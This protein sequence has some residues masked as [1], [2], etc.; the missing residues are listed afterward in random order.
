MTSEKS[1]RVRTLS[2]KAPAA[3]RVTGETL[4][5]STAAG[6]NG[7]HDGSAISILE[8]CPNSLLPRP[9]SPRIRQKVPA[10]YGVQEQCLPFTAATAL[11]LLILSPIS[12]GF[13]A[14]GDVPLGARSFRSPIET[15]LP[16]DEQDLRVYWVR[17]D[18]TRGFAGNAFILHAGFGTESRGMLT[19]GISF[20]D[21]DDQIEF[22]KLHLPYVLR[23]APGCDLLFTPLLNRA[24]NGFEVLSG[25]VEADW[26]A[27][28][29]NLVLRRPA[30]GAVGV[31]AGEPIAQAIVTRQ[32]DRSTRLR[33]L[34]PSSEDAR[35]LHQ[36]VTQWYADHAKHR[37][38][39]K[40][41]AR[42]A[43]LPDGEKA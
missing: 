40:A 1:H 32:E 33:Q 21:R 24:G 2:R 3:R 12:F 11:G 28:P 25:L 22:C 39:Y 20:F 8:L 6:D 14:L 43:R 10:G 15:R 23:T 26:Y 35:L 16:A 38:A 37:S 41:K 13:C 29:V 19:P 17:D 5:L 31:A 18:P 27:H 42:A 4:P 34:I 9:A 30:V 36:E 7:S